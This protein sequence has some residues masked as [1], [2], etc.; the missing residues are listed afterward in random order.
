MEDYNEIFG[1]VCHRCGNRTAVVINEKGMR[2]I[3][4]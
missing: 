3:E 2:R 4:T 1:G